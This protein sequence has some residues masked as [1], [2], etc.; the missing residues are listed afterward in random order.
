MRASEANKN[1]WEDVPQE[2]KD[3]FERLGIPEAERKSL[4]GVGA[5]YDCLTSDTIVFTNPK[6]PTKI[7]D[8]KPGDKI[9][10]W[11]NKSNKIV[12]AKVKNVW[13]AGK[14][15]VFKVKIKNHTI[16]ASD[17]HPLLALS[18]SKKP[19]HRKGSYD[20]DW[21][22]LG[23]L[24]KGTLVA[25]AKDYPSH[26]TSMQLKQPRIETTAIGKPQ[27]GK[28]YSMDVSYK[29]NVVVLP[30]CSGEDLMWLFGLFLGDGYIKKEKNKNAE[31]INFAIPDDQPELRDELAKIMKQDFSYDLQSKYKY[32]VSVNS[33]IIARFFHENKMFGKAK[34]KQVPQWVFSLPKTQIL[35]FLAGFMDADG[36]V[37]DNNKN[38]DP[39]LT[40]ANKGLLESMKNLSLYCGIE[41]S[42]IRDFSYRKDEKQYTGYRFNL[43]GNTLQL[44]SRHPLKAKRILK[45]KYYH[46]NIS[47]RGAG[48]YFKKYCSDF[49]GFARIDEIVPAGE[50]L[51]YDIEV[52][53]FH[54][55]V[56]NG[57]VVHNSEVMY[58]N[59]REDLE[60]QGVVF[61]SMDE[62][63][64]QYPELVKKHFGK[65]VPYN[66]NKFAA[67][68]TAVW[69]GGSFV[70]IPKN[71]KVNIPLQA[72][73]RINAES[74]GQFE[75][76]LIIGDTGSQVHYIEGCTAPRF[77]SQS[78]HSA[79][80]EV[81]A[82]ENS[83]LRYTTI[84]NWANNI[85][86]LVTKRAFAYRN[87]TV[88]W[89][90]GNLGSKVTMKYPA[91]YLM[92]EGA[93]GE[94]LSIALAGK[95]QHQ[96]AGAKIVHLASNTTSKI[97]SK[98]ISKDGG[99]GSYR[100]L[101]K[102]IKGCKNVKSSV[103]C[104]A[105][106]L[107]KDSRSDTYP[108]IEID[109][110]TATIAHEAKV[111]KINDDEIFYLRS[112]GLSETEALTLIILG[113]IQPFIKTLPLEYSVELNR[114]IEMEMENSVG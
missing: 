89:V 60:K 77:T 24:K 40:S 102:V 69:S 63:L 58:H 68:N 22:P 48:G 96:D 46:R 21:V 61:L 75:R 23:K 64:K 81:I 91:I 97:T 59:I 114:L 25:I 55:F 78:L 113:F 107:D 83:S 36:G 105:L 111:G 73:F 86:N 4:A 95:D 3:T 74:F 38:H 106:I 82:K 19:R 8:V 103:V 93:K 47:A 30:Q 65:I 17:N 101:L 34:T 108:Y 56:A 110:P 14:K 99:R 76:T 87:S 29:Y 72:Y 53:G 32:Y 35:A 62:G 88:E 39:I 26:G 66:D 44:P 28:T 12:P 100:G 9:F 80:V 104:D 15:P 85:Y 33:T 92:E 52:E 49:I 98:S 84:Q 27:T 41:T 37:R 70:Y 50:E 51:T 7:I 54:N 90:D 67:L 94:V 13:P 5:Q 42:K 18:Y 2:V 112:R 11:D 1:K 57:I 6:G 43:S 20:L 109:E 16:K 71:V 79:V 10:A 45:K 31:R